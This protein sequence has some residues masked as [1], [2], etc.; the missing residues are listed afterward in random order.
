MA[1]LNDIRNNLGK[2]PEKE[3]E[4]A[5]SLFAKIGIDL[6]TRRNELTGT[7]VGGFIFQN[8]THS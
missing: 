3:K 7:I 8:K 4:I 6:T 2:M 1:T 5:L